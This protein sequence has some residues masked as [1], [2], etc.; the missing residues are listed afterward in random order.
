MAMKTSHID[1]SLLDSLP[2]ALVI[3]QADGHIAWASKPA[4]DYLGKIEN[5]ATALDKC[6]ADT[7]FA[8]WHKILSQVSDSPGPAN[9]Q[10]INCHGLSG[11]KKIVNLTISPLNSAGGHDQDFFALFEDVTGKASLERQ[12]AH[13]ERLAA[14]GKFSAELAHELNNPLDGILRYVNLAIR[15]CDKLEDHHPAKYLLQARRGLMRMVRIITELLE[16]SRSSSA[17]LLE[18]N[19]QHIIEEA[20]NVLEPR[21][22]EH[23]VTFERQFTQ[24]L[25]LI[26]TGNLYQVFCNLFRNA[27]EAMPTGGTLSISAEIVADNLRI[28]IADTG[29]GLPKGDTERIFQP[30]FTTKPAG[31][32]TGLGLAICREV[33]QK[34]Q[35]Q[36]TAANRQDCPGAVI[37]LLIPLSSCQTA[38]SPG[39]PLS[40]PRPESI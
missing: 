20:L 23:S 19:I 40:L 9:F 39:S 28:T 18:D 38:A 11:S 14:L 13:A 12:L 22:V 29:V 10:N 27:I 35:G 8:D 16:F 15:L 6:T 37:T 7:R 26:R 36:I 30:F 24:N 34:Y 5:L 33:I 4:A 21:A 17:A 2:L 32:G 3:F 1:F 31:Q 25:P